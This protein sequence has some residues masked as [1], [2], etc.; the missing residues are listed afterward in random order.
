M[1]SPYPAAPKARRTVKQILL[2]YFYWTYPRGS[3]H[4]DIMVTVILLFIFLTPQIKGWSYGDKPSPIGGPLH[5]I[6]VIGNDGQG[7]I[8]TVQASDMSLDLHTTA[9]D[10][11][12]KKALRKA[13]EPVTGDA[14]VVDHWETTTDAQGNSVWKVWAHR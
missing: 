11:V 8:V 5:P 14:V 10:A 13:I 1:T 2:S 9:P 12:V 7:V 4:Y 3:F 6:Q